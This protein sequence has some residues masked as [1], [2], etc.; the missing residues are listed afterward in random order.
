MQGLFKG[1][2]GG[3]QHQ[4]PGGPSM[5]RSHKIMSTAG[6]GMAVVLLA[7]CGNGTAH[8]PVAAAA[9]P[10]QVG[11]PKVITANA[12]AC[13]GAQGVLGHLAAD[14]VLWSPTQKPFD[15]GIAARIRVLAGELDAQASQAD[16][17]R[18]DVVIHV[19]AQAFTKVSAAMTSRKRAS[20]NTAIRDSRLAYKVLKRTCSL[21]CS[22]PEYD[23]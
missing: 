19:S 17:K 6:L 7:G 21:S 8:K 20:V 14:T 22:R 12:K 13:A 16:S 18:V 15:K 2:A 3:W 10:S 1:R 5:A 23:A 9:S 4:T 11:T